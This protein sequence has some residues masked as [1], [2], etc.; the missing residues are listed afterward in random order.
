MELE[1][2]KRLITK[3]LSLFGDSALFM[4]NVDIRGAK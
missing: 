3:W 1:I 4:L 2:K